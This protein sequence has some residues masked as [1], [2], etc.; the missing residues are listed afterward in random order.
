MG[1]SRFAVADSLRAALVEFD[2]STFMKEFDDL[3]K[4]DVQEAVDDICRRTGQSPS[5]VWR[6]LFLILEGRTGFRVPES[7]ENTVQIQAV[8]EVCLLGRLDSA[9][10][11]LKKLCRALVTETT[12]Q[13]HND[14]LDW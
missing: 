7:V 3:M 10:E 11:C 6:M 1:T 4:S 12:P 9:A 8:E 14:F 5:W 13:V 2:L